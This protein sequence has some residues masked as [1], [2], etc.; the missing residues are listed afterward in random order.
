MTGEIA[1]TISI[2][3]AAIVLFVTELLR[4][5]I[6]AILIML[7]LPWLGLIEP[8]E[9]FSGLASNA[10]IAIIAVMIMGYGLEASGATGM[11][12]GPIID[13]AGNRER[14]MI[15][16]LA[17]SAGFLSAFMQNI[18]VVALYLPVIR[19]VNRKTDLSLN[20]ILMPVGFA[21]LLGGNLTM[22]GS[23]N[24]IILNDLLQQRGAEPYNLFSVTPIGI[25]LLLAGIAYMI[26]VGRRFLPG[27]DEEESGEEREQ[28]Q[29]IE[30]RGLAT[31]LFRCRVPE[32]SD[33]TG[34]TQ[35]SSRLWE[36]FNLHLI[37]IREDG[38]IEY[39][40]WR[41]TRFSGGQK[42]LLLGREDDVGRFARAY[43]MDYE[44]R[45]RFDEELDDEAAEAVFAELM[46]P[47]RSCFI[48]QTI[49]EVAV[50]KNYSVNPVMLAR[51]D[52]EITGDFSDF[53]IRPGDIIVLF[54]R[55]GNI[56][57]A[58]A[59][60]ELL[61]LTP[62]K[63]RRKGKKSPGLAF[64]LFLFSI[65][66]VIAGIQLALALFTG[67]LLMVLA[68]IVPVNRIYRAVD[69][70]TVFLL[71]GL[72][73][74]GIAMEDSGTADFLA[75]RMMELMGGGHPLV[76]LMAVALLASFFTLFMSNVASTVVLVP[77]VMIMGSE[78]GIDPR[79][80]A[81]LAGVCASNSFILPTHQVN[82]YFMNA[83]DY[84]SRDYFR[85]GLFLTL[86]YALLAVAAVYL[87]YI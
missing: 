29:I 47:P 51:G 81:L 37:A 28:R 12:T 10:V 58:A 43:D 18:G 38:D 6:T 36:E 65:V 30:E 33:L 73:P 75:R 35:E 70:Q 4:L 62:V 79:G 63:S 44:R 17:G 84:S 27:E 2:L 83:G 11:L 60:E 68:G 48:G 8:L 76:I 40:P 32:G 56:E 25:I 24:L 13:L 7:L 72:I 59:G 42:L 69:W 1:L 71:T 46:V 61:A 23:G 77:L 55:P 85:V 57:A 50:R 52:R 53:R 31:T 26:L 66:L 34:L 78:A 67:A 82:A 20:R 16:V 45:G 3:V 14:R 54:G 49:R 86:I 41:F 80:L 22:V 74:L 39:A 9:A 5:D 64:G 19:K 21:A 87:L 15:S